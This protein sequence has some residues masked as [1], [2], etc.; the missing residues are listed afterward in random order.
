MVIVFSSDLKQV[1]TGYCPKDGI[2]KFF[3]GKIEPCDGQYDSSEETVARNCALRE[4]MAEAGVPRTNISF[5]T[6]FH[7]RRWGIYN[8]STRIRVPCFQYFFLACA[9]Q[10]ISLP[11][12]V[13]EEEE[14]TDR[15]FVDIGKVLASWD[16]PHGDKDRINPIHAIGLK[17]ALDFLEKK[18]AHDPRF[19]SFF[20]MLSSLEYE[21]IHSGSYI[22]QIENEMDNGRLSRV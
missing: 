2:H 14:M 9:K 7:V 19:A 16:L 1:A 22:K 10:G 20:Y 8:P 11:K 3:G 21:G 18:V 4:L 5:I 15:K 17:R 13:A 12:R 6:K